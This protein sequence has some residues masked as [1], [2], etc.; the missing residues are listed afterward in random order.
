MTPPQPSPN[1]GREFNLIPRPLL[2]E[3][4]GASQ[5]KKRF[6][7]SPLQRSDMERGFRGEVS[8]IDA[9]N[10]R[11]SLKAL[12][13]QKTTSTLKGAILGHFSVLKSFS[14]PCHL[15]RGEVNDS[16][17]SATLFRN[18]LQNCTILLLDKYCISPK[19]LYLSD[20]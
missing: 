7:K 1:S 11:T 3:R 20:G 19:R 4:R 6:W 8:L 17:S 15:W 10:Y 18:I 9:Y 12:W 5:A 16:L 2:H 13:L 14:L